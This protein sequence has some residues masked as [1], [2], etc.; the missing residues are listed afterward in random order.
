MQTGCL[1]V[2]L[3]AA[4]VFHISSL[5]PLPKDL[6][7][8]AG[9]LLPIA[10]PIHS[11]LLSGLFVACNS[12]LRYVLQSLIYCTVIWSGYCHLQK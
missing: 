11:D 3:V 9:G 6:W 12:S 10:G 2:N 4:L 5:Q 7:G 8:L 1:A